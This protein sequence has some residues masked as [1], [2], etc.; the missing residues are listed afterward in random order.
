MQFNFKLI[1]PQTT[2][3]VF[4]VTIDVNGDHYLVTDCNPALPELPSLLA[5]L[6]Q[7]RDFYGFIKSIRGK[8]RQAACS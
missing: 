5:N 6:N 4:S 8:F 3:R 2:Q 7:S 1:D